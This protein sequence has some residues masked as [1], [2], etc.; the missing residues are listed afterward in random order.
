[1]EENN[2]IN[3]RNEG[4]RGVAGHNPNR[5]CFL[6]NDGRYYCYEVWDPDKKKNV[7]VQHEIGTDGFTE[8]WTFF[9]DQTDH[10]HDLND[11]YENELKDDLFQLR[12]Q[13]MDEARF[14]DD[15]DSTMNPWNDER[16]SGGSPEDVLLADPV[17]DDPM[18]AKVREVVDTQFTDAQKDFYFDHFGMQKQMKEMR[19]AEAKQTGK[20]PTNSAMTNRKNK[21]LDKV[22]KALGV[23]RVKRHKYPKK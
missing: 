22:A 18:E 11:R 6:S 14:D 5:P 2:E 3:E 9:L 21:M 8:E 10:E 12:M 19:Q 1:M 13:Q 7:I 15:T 16:L 23:K 20:L 17:K 4:I